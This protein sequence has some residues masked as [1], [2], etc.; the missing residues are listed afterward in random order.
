[1]AWSTGAALLVANCVIWLILIR[2]VDQLLRLLLYNVSGCF[3]GVALLFAFCPWTGGDWHPTKISLDFKNR[4]IRVLAWHC[5]SL[6]GVE[7][8]SSPQV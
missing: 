1:M 8:W 5:L 3:A 7:Q 4:C 6:I 2:Q